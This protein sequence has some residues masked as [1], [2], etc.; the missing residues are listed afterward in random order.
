[1]PIMNTIYA[2]REGNIYFLYNGLVPRRDPQFDWSLPVDGADPRTE[3]Q[4]IHPL[5]ELPQVLNPTDGYVQNC[6]SSPFTTC[7]LSNPN[8]QSFPRYMVEDANDDK[9]RAKRSRE[10]LSAM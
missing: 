8:R 7:E 10:M 9:R 1:F 6:N 3:W 2:D 5:A 4:G